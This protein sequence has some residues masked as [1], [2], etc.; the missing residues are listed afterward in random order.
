[1]T[2]SEAYLEFLKECLRDL[3]SVR[4]KRMF[5]GAGVFADG[6]MFGLVIDDTL[7]L[8]AD[9]ETQPAFE[10]E[11]LAPFSYSRSGRA[12]ALSYWRAPE[13]LLDDG[14]EMRA[15]ASR[16]LSVARRSASPRRGGGKRRK[17]S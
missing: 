4:A 15:W 17:A 9:A 7:Y 3:G 12:V 13:R 8:K 11:G 16:A 1:M 5:G 2:A 10:A 14:E 6:V